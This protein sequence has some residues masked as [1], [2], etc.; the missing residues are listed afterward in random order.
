MEK[1]AKCRVDMCNATDVIQEKSRG[2]GVG[3]DP[4]PQ[5]IAG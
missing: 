1:Y 3:S 2:G 5:A 4:P